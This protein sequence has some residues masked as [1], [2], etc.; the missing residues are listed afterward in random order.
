LTFQHCLK[1]FENVLLLAYP[2]VKI[3]T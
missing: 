1:V 2:K 3:F